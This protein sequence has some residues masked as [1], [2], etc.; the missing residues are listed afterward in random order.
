M[1]YILMLHETFMLLNT[2]NVTQKKLHKGRA[3]ARGF[4][5]FLQLLYF[6]IILQLQN[7]S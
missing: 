6:T 7:I 5:R 1:C 4:T 3:G 2:S